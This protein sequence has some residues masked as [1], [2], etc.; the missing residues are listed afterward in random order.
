L[1]AL[2]FARPS[3]QILAFRFLESVGG[4]GLRTVGA[5]SIALLLKFA[6]AAAQLA[7]FR[8]KRFDFDTALGKLS[9]GR[10]KCRFKLLDF[11]HEIHHGQ[12]N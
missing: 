1:A 9:K 10:F 5:I 2:F 3:S 8:T 12:V 6:D 11:V 4:R 7:V